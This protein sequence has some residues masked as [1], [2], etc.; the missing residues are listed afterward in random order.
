M[1]KRSIDSPVYSVP[2]AAKYIHTDL[3][4]VRKAIKWGY[5]PTFDF[6]S[7]KVTKKVLD[8]FLD[9]YTGGGKGKKLQEEIEAKENPVNEGER[10][11]II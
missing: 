8:E 11:V 7:T 6:G 10:R 4:L 2:D 1:S 3:G 5:I 9:K